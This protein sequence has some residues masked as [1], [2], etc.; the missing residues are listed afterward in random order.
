MENVLILLTI[1]G[2]LG[3]FDNFWHHELKEALPSKRSARNELLL[4]TIREYIYAV[5]FFLLAWYECHGYWSIVI[6]GL[7]GIEI[8]ITILDFLEEDRTRKLLALER[9]LHTILA[10]NFGFFIAIVSPELIRWFELP[11]E[12]VATD[13]G[14]WSWVL[15]VFSVGVFF[16]GVRDMCAVIKLSRPEKWKKYPIR[17]GSKA[18]ARMILVTGA[19]GF[20][21]QSL[22]RTLIKNGDN[23]I[24]LTRQ[25]EKAEDLFGPHVKI[26]TKLDEIESNTVFN[27]VISLTGAPVVGG[28]WTKKRKQLLIDS[29]L[30]DLKSLKTMCERL[31]TKPKILINA[32]AIGFY[33]IR[34][35]ELITEKEQGQ[36]IFQ[37]ELCQARENAAL[38]FEEY[39]TRI[40]NL[41]IGLVFDKDGGAFPQMARPIKFALGAVFGSGKQWMSWI[42]RSDLIRVMLFL[43]SQEQLS[44]AINAT[45]PEPTTNG[46][47]T[48]KVADKFNRPVFFK[49]PDYVLKTMLGELS[50]LFLE[51][52][53]VIPEKLLEAGFRFNHNSFDGMLSVFDKKEKLESFEEVKVYYNEQCPV[54]N[55]EVSHYK[56][57]AKVDECSIEFNDINKDKEIL[58]MYRLSH[59]D[60][61]RRMYAHDENGKLVSGI[62]AFLAIWRRLPKY[63]FLAKIISL[64]LVYCL[65]DLV[66]EVIMVPVLAYFNERRSRKSLV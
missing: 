60:V 59:A 46:D 6:S 51:G 16:W 10:I 1:Q 39:G 45:A 31:T 54:C 7:L 49:V 57:S 44:G 58:S 40:C 9:V 50:Q 2:V 65:A 19:T 43:L 25:Y 34:K 13:Y 55:F 28:L 32:S 17:H 26:V 4:H 42:D 29:R 62:D 56:R 23:V 18:N 22:C 66:Y 41:R 53:R 5:I 30:N 33:G 52:Q 37:S 36:E 15:T 21:G 63:N 11:T 3:G 61:K 27:A 12:L 20:I 48:K 14:L 24:V 64:P 38:A 35:D 8:V 47:F